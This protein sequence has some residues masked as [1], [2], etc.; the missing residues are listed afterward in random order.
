M[1]R[2]AGTP[3]RTSGTALSISLSTVNWLLLMAMLS[4]LL[5]ATT[6][7]HQQP[8]GSASEIGGAASMTEVQPGR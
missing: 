8:A 3:D 1:N 7:S 6:V 4:A 5:L 2:L